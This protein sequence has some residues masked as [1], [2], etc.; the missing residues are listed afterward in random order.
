MIGKVIITNYNFVNDTDR[1]N[2]EPTVSHSQMSMISVI[3]A[4]YKSLTIEHDSIKGKSALAT[5]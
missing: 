5:C 3:L 4:K 2:V 1:R